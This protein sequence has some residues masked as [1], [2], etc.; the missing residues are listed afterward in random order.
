MPNKTLRTCSMCHTASAH[1][2]LGRARRD[3]SSVG[4]AKNKS[5]FEVAEKCTPNLANQEPALKAVTAKD[6]SLSLQHGLRTGL[7]REIRCLIPSLSHYRG[8]SPTISSAIPSRLVRPCD[9]AAELNEATSD[10]TTSASTRM[11]TQRHQVHHSNH[12]LPN[13]L[14]ESTCQFPKAFVNQAA[15]AAVG[16]LSWLP[17]ENQLLLGPLACA[18]PLCRTKPYA[19]AACATLPQLTPSWDEHVEITAA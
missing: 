6:P 13:I 2:L 7:S 15:S 8:G 5:Q 17:P 12:T 3:Y 10:L 16:M 19:L 1:T 14:R 9:H 11:R 4:H 18:C